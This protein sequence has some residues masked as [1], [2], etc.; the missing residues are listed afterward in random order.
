MNLFE[1]INEGFFES[2]PSVLLFQEEI[3][4][5]LSKTSILNQKINVLE[6]LGSYK[7]FVAFSSK[8]GILST[9]FF[10]HL[11]ISLT[12]CIYN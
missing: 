5:F 12:Y 4:A 7:F 2:Q 9:Q 1:L 8:N 10:M 3:I 11:S 6:A